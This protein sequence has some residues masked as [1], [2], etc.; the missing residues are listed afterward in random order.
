MT[1]RDS[2]LTAA[3]AFLTEAAKRRHHPNNRNFYWT[4]IGWAQNAR[5]R[6]AQ[7]TTPHQGALFA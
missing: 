4:L 6:A 5:R 1:E 7:S 3:R 2:H